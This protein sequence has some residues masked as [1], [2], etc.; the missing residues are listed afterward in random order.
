MKKILLSL[1]VKSFVH[2][3]EV[4]WCTHSP[5][6]RSG[7]LNCDSYPMWAKDGY[8]GTKRGKFIDGVQNETTKKIIKKH[9]DYGLDN[10]QVHGKTRSR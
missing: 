5:K 10:E 6:K 2:I 9:F 3:D 8:T 4:H 7:V 1:D